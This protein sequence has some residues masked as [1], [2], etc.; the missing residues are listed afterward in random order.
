MIRV[1]LYARYSSENQRETSIEDQFRN[2]E[3][4]AKHEGWHIIE[5]YKDLAITG[6]TVDRPGYLAMLRDAKAKRFEILLVDDLS[7]LSRDHVETEKA[8]RRFVY[9]GVPLIG[10]SDGIDTTAK[11]HKML[12]GVKG[13]RFFSTIFVKKH[14]VA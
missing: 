11:G 12:S 10:V 3:H 7:R 13:L 8:R 4:R 14:A 6:S 1:A 9:W 2:C 5:R